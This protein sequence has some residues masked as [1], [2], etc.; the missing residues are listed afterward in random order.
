VGVI[1][2]QVSIAAE[3]E[4]LHAVRVKEYEP[5]GQAIASETQKQSKAHYLADLL[6]RPGFHYLD[7]ER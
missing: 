3:K 2:K 6:R 4:R 7:L 5:V 1:Y